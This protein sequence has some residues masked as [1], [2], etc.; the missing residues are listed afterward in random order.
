ME[1]VKDRPGHR[2]SGQRELVN[3]DSKLELV[4]V[5]A[6]QSLNWSKVD[7]VKSRTGQRWTWSK[8]GSVASHLPASL[9]LRFVVAVAAAL[10]VRDRDW[11]F[12]VEMG[13]NSA[14]DIA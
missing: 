7:L 4:K 1:L 6:G 2:G 14:R 10:R 9:R 3:A 13:R 11:L 8:V 12:T 5:R